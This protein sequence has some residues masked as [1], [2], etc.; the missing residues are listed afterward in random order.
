MFT[1]K[2]KREA[3][4]YCSFQ[5]CRRRSWKV[6][7]TNSSFIYCSGIAVSKQKKV[8]RFK[9]VTRYLRYT[10]VLVYSYTV[11]QHTHKSIWGKFLVQLEETDLVTRYRRRVYTLKSNLLLHGCCSFSYIVLHLEVNLILV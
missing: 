2:C 8:Y 6:F 11:R 10:N 4:Y 1:G 9:V 3:S 7:E 5:C